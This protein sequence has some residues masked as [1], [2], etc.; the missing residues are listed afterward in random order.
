MG[1]GAAA[2]S[3]CCSNDGV[4]RR[5]LGLSSSSRTL[6]RSLL[7]L[8]LGR[9]GQG[10]PAHGRAPVGD[11]QRGDGELELGAAP[12]KL[13]GDPVVLRR[14]ALSLAPPGRR[15]GSPLAQWR[16]WT[17]GAQAE[18]GG[19]GMAGVPVS[20]SGGCSGRRR[21]WWLGRV[22]SC[23]TPAHYTGA[24]LEASGGDACGKAELGSTPPAWDSSTPEARRRADR[25]GDW[26]GRR[27]ASSGR[28]FM[29]V[30]H[31]DKITVPLSHQEEGE[32]VCT[33]D[34]WAHKNFLL[35]I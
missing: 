12:F 32:K 34:E 6:L 21:N 20:D 10:C 4:L 23:L 25:G 28:A 17:T 15:R 35:L 16:T 5:G 27:V 2:C 33:N 13:D 31:G 29:A 19:G 1:R 30:R 22:G 3:R 9:G 26:T 7:Q 11:K 18:V 14:A 24:G 8:G